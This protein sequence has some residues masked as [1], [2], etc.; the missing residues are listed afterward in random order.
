MK[1]I[2]LWRPTPPNPLQAYSGSMAPLNRPLAVSGPMALR[3]QPLARQKAVASLS[4]HPTFRRM[5]ANKHWTMTPPSIL[6]CSNTSRLLPGPLDGSA[7]QAGGSKQ[8]YNWKATQHSGPCTASHWV[9]P[10]NGP[11]FA[12]SWKLS[13]FRPMPWTWSNANGNNW[14]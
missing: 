2:R 1:S 13:F 4:S 7:R 3:S 6:F 8:C 9:H 12:H 10:S 14:A 5:R 11:P